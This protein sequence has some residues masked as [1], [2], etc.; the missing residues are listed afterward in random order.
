MPY[1][2]FNSVSNIKNTHLS[3]FCPPAKP[4]L[5]VGVRKLRRRRSTDSVVQRAAPIKSNSPLPNSEIT[6]TDRPRV[7]SINEHYATG[8][9]QMQR[10]QS[11]T[12]CSVSA[13]TTERETINRR[14]S[15][16]VYLK[17]LAEISKVLENGINKMEEKRIEPTHLKISTPGNAEMPSTTINTV[18][19]DSYH[20]NEDFEK[21]KKKLVHKIYSENEAVRNIL[22]KYGLLDNEKYETKEKEESDVTDNVIYG[23]TESSNRVEISSNL[24]FNH[25][26]SSYHEKKSAK[27]NSTTKKNIFRRKR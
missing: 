3:S 25:T 12:I 13:R 7:A 16:D 23:I 8:V 22:S 24:T 20:Q 4:N 14:K 17:R 6:V 26:H 27:V 9:H 18:L 19:R 10:S 5:L 11:A 21:D 15:I 2:D 1:S